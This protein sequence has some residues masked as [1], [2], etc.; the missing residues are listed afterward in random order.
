MVENGTIS[1]AEAARHPQANVITRAVGAD[2]D[3]LELDK[4]TGQ[5][6]AGDRLLLC[7]DGLSKPVPEELL[8]ELLSGDDAAA[9]ERLVTAA[10]MAKVTDNVTAVTIDFTASGSV[11]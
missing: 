6:Q 3:L 7:S 2:I 5:L 9:A 8:A 11:G 10:L 1:E 4:R